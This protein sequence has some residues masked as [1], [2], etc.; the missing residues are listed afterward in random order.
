MELSD[1]ILDAKKI[2]DNRP[3]DL[4]KWESVKKKL[5][6]IGF[7]KVFP[8]MRVDMDFDQTEEF[9]KI[10]DIINKN[11]NKKG[12][13]W[14]RFTKE[15]YEN[16]KELQKIDSIEEKIELLTGK[17]YNLSIL[18]DIIAYVFI[19]SNDLDNIQH[20]ENY[21][22]I[23]KDDFKKINFL[24]KIQKSL[25]KEKFGKAFIYM[26]E[27]KDLDKATD[28]LKTLQLLNKYMNQ[29][30]IPY[31]KQSSGNYEVVRD[32]SK[33]NK[34][35]NL[36]ILLSET[37]YKLDLGLD[38][39]R[40]IRLNQND[41][42]NIK[43]LEE[44]PF[45][46]SLQRLKALKHIGYQGI[47][48]YKSNK[49]INFDNILEILKMDDDVVGAIHVLA[50]NDYKIDDV[51]GMD[52][53]DI[54][55][56]RKIAE[57]SRKEQEKGIGGSHIYLYETEDSEIF[58]LYLNNLSIQNQKTTLKSILNYSS[59]QKGLGFNK[60]NRIDGWLEEHY[61]ILMRDI[62]FQDI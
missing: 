35:E 23:L 12:R 39:I 55:Q 58:G 16:I 5:K 46:E 26:K 29:E 4:E 31:N 10:F 47:S 54:S 25:K 33:I 30:K 41:L 27:E 56:I 60:F 18:R 43:S 59:E 2:Q 53:Q 52:K 7:S 8:L 28:F 17:G 38:L 6:S 32:I 51:Y 42:D 57:V 22:S 44:Y 3:L 24:I 49:G 11:L 15:S 50:Y 14:K 1:L 40:H 34:L 19:S 37:G 61:K 45:E 9:F 48:N 21:N 36:L 13:S 20:S 62:C